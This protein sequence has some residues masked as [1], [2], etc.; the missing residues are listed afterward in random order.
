MGSN[1]RWNQYTKQY[2]E[3]IPSDS[4]H[5]LAQHLSGVCVAEIDAIPL[6]QV[7]DYVKTLK[8]SLVLLEH[9]SDPILHYS[10]LI[11]QISDLECF[12]IT[13]RYTPVYEREIIFPKWLFE[14][15]RQTFPEIKF[16]SKQYRYSCLNRTPK[17]HRIDLYN[18]I[19]NNLTNAVYTFNNV[20]PNTSIAVNYPLITWPGDVGGNDHSINHDAYLNSYLN[21]VT[22]TVVD[23]EFSSEKTWKPIA[24]GQLF[25]T[26]A[27]PGH[28]HWL[29]SLGIETFVD[30][31]INSIVEVLQQDL[32]QMYYQN[33]DKIKHNHNIFCKRVLHNQII[34]TAIN[35]LVQ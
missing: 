2:V 9:T 19:K 20:D 34:K 3:I 14:F 25:A 18:K 17:Q 28:N 31:N 22:E 33:I 5:D 10:E 13:S 6:N 1:L 24:A 16:G 15:S 30:N 21:I 26:L 12:L 32:E 23:T 7:R 27:H 35:I 4:M 29:N 8:G 11:D